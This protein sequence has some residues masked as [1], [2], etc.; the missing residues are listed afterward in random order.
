GKAV[1]ENKGKKTTTKGKKSDELENEQKK[2]KSTEEAVLETKK[3][4]GKTPAKSEAVKSGDAPVVQTKEPEV[5]SE[6]KGRKSAAVEVQPV[7]ADE[8][9]KKGKKTA[10]KSSDKK[11]TNK[12]S[13]NK[14]VKQDHLL[15][16]KEQ[17][18]PVLHET[19]KIQPAGLLEKEKDKLP[20]VHETE[21]MQPVALL[22]DKSPVKKRGRPGN[23]SSVKEE[24]VEKP[25]VEQQK[26]AKKNPKVEKK[27]EKKSANQKKT[28]KEIKHETVIP[29]SELQSQDNLKQD[30]TPVTSLF[31]TSDKQKTSIFSAVGDKSENKKLPTFF[32][33]ETE[34]QPIFDDIKSQLPIVFDERAKLYQFI[35]E[36]QQSGD[37]AKDKK[38]DQKSDKKQDQEDEK[39]PY[40]SQAVDTN[41][42]FCSPN[43]L[44]LVQ[45]G[46]KNVIADTLTDYDMKVA[47]KERRVTFTTIISDN[48]EK[49]ARVMAIRFGTEENA[50][51]FAELIERK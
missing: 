22:N 51:R 4:R 18:L 30:K 3:G 47:I 48:N 41:V 43:R 27:L 32:T 5:K 15:D 46:I 26:R 6:K 42:I 38:Q 1:S 7:V 45:E 23:K 44:I 37:M 14:P 33:K 12:K 28:K 24:K 34:K 11:S 50:K 31:T 13:E 16:E 19:E 21:K 35:T 25:K 20:I 10:T 39:L 2:G 9:S 36:E 40:W 17:Q 49:K 8:K 29:V